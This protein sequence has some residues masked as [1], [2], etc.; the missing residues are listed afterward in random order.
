VEAGLNTFTIALRVAGGDEKG[1][2]YLEEKLG[3]LVL[4][5]YKYGEL[6]LQVG[7]VSNLIQ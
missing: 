7:G 2:Q 1:A 3:H 6:V 4:G 5:G